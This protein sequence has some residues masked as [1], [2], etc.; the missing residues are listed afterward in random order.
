MIEIL[1]KERAMRKVII[2]ITNDAVTIE[3]NGIPVERKES[4]D[5][6]LVEFDWD[7]L[8][9]GPDNKEESDEE[10]YCDEI[11]SSFV[12]GG[13]EIRFQYKGKMRYLDVGP[14]TD[15]IHVRGHIQVGDPSY[16]PANNNFRCFTRS[17]MTDCLLLN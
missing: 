11:D 6:T 4:V 16:S 8:D 10:E 3:T 14:E 9:E 15:L 5:R 1:D 17:L 7:S 13:D 12:R 2:T